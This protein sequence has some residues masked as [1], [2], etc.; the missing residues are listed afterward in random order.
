MRRGVASIH[1]SCNLAYIG[2]TRR[3]MKSRLKEYRRNIQNEEIYNSSI[4]SHR[5]FYN[6]YFG[7]TKASTVSPPISAS[8]LNFHE[9]FLHLEKF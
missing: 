1:C 8:H 7:I 6:H 9:K 2:Q 4:V 5:R 3:R